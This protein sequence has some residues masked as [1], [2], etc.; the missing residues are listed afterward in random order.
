VSPSPN[1]P[2]MLAFGETTV[3]WLRETLET[4]PPGGVTLV[5]EH[6]IESTGQNAALISELQKL[7]LR[8]P[9]QYLR[10]SSA[11]CSP[12]T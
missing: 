8:G 7:K 12:I 3:P 2:L 5:R 9:P 6:N 4:R 11:S 1:I 10:S